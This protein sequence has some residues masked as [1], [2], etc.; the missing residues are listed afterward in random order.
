MIKKR[1]DPDTYD[2]VEMQPPP[3]RAAFSDSTWSCEFHCT[4]ATIHGFS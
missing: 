2:A 4:G 3:A 1:F